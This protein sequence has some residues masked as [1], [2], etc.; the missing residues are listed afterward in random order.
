ML[1]FDLSSPLPPDARGAAVAL[2]NFDGLHAG[3]R[4]VVARAGMMAKHLGAK[5]GV[6]TFEPPP[7]RFF[8]PDAP[9]FR[10]MTIRRREIALGSEE[11]RVGK[12]CRSRWSPYH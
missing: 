11:R 6:A 10:L 12:E 7:R 9:P 4:A 1:S 3:H 2:G 8:Q 5:H